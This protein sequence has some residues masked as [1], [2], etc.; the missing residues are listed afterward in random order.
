MKSRRLVPGIVTVVAAIAIAGCSSGPATSAAPVTITD[1]SFI[2]A[3]NGGAAMATIVKAFEKANPNITV[4][5]NTATQPSYDVGLASDL[6]GGTATDVFEI[7]GVGNY[8]RYESK[9]Q[10]AAITGEASAAY[11][12]GI[13]AT[14][15]AGGKQYGL[16]TSFSPDVLFYNK[17]LFQAAGVAYPTNNWTRSDEVTAAKKIADPAKGVYGLYEPATFAEFS[18]ALAQNGASFLSKSGTKADFATPAGIA[19]AQWLI[20]NGRVGAPTVPPAAT[21]TTADAILFQ[22][23]KLGMDL[24]PASDIPLFAKSPTAWG[25]AIEPGN[26][27]KA[28]AVSSDAVG[29]SAKSKHLAAAE[30]W[31][32]YLSSSSVE[33]RIRIANGWGLPALSNAAEDSSYFA[34]GDSGLSQT[35]FASANNIAPTPALGTHGSQIEAIIDNALLEAQ[36]GKMSV[37]QCLASAS[38]QIDA[39]LA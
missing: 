38:T 29:I 18:A 36:S 37:Q 16:P 11:N 3:V 32:E 20:D 19:A 33:A 12:R 13:L 39:I 31:A 23:G 28:I 7:D 9:G 10:L 4:I 8:L 24:A 27:V 6:D 22:Q 1:S 26:S 15:S 2:S 35:V 14:Y 25:V 30:K 5:V 17:S 34:P 21:G